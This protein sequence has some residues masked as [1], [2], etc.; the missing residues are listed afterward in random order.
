MTGSLNIYRKYCWVI[1]SEISKFYEIFPLTF[2]DFHEN[3]SLFIIIKKMKGVNFCGP[4][5]HIGRIMPY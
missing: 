4:T 5:F 2:F 1:P 3:F